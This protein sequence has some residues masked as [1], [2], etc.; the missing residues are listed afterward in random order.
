MFK[1]VPKNRLKLFNAVI[2][3]LFVLGLFNI[4]Y[5]FTWENGFPVSRENLWNPSW[6]LFSPLLYLGHKFVTNKEAVKSKRNL[7]HFLP[8]IAFLFFA[9]AVLAFAD[10]NHPW[11]DF[12]FRNYQNSYYVITFSLVGYGIATFRR[13][14]GSKRNSFNRRDVVVV[15]LAAIY[16]MAGIITA[17]FYLAWGLIHFDLGMDYRYFSYGLLLFA[18]VQILFY[19]SIPSKN[20]SQNNVYDVESEITTYKNNMLD[21]ELTTKMKNRVIA[22]YEDS[23]IYLTPDLSLNKLAADLD[24]PKHNLSQLFNFHF[25]KNFHSFTA[26]YR[27]KFAI[28]LLN[29]NFGLLKIETLAYSCGFN[30]QSSFNKYFKLYT[31]K[32]PSEYQINLVQ[33]NKKHQAKESNLR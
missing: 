25:K 1:S 24:I 12:I 20:I 33:T 16:I 11:E 31:G 4:V 7:L 19:W 23:Q 5:K 8:F 17:I 2:I 29:N 21:P 26:S 32:S 9:L 10:L 30:S 6:L 18:D 27:I 15:I 14:L 28:N 3:A 22:Y 13:V